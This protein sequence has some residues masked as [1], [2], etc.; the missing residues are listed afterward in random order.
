MYSG[1]PETTRTT[2]ASRLAEIFQ[3]Y[4]KGNCSRAGR[5]L[6]HNGDDPGIVRFHITCVSVLRRQRIEENAGENNG[7]GRSVQIALCRQHKSPLR[8]ELPPLMFLPKQLA[9]PKWQ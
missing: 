7:N 2:K 1:N 5:L 8:L 3:I 4:T 9:G 6:K